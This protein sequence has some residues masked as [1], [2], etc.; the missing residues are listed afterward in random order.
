LRFWQTKKSATTG[1]YSISDP[2]DNEKVLLDIKRQL[3]EQN[4]MEH[5]YIY[6]KMIDDRFLLQGKS[7]VDSKNN[8]LE[9]NTLSTTA[10][11]TGT[12]SFPYGGSVYYSNYLSTGCEVKQTYLDRYATSKAMDGALTQSILFWF[13]DAAT[14]NFS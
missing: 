4:A 9:Y 6:K 7:Y 2:G 13:V 3:I 12:Y 14:S 5:Y 11:V 8:R 10:T 1:I